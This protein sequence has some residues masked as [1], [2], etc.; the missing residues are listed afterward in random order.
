MVRSEFENRNNW[1]AHVEPQSALT[2]ESGRANGAGRLAAAQNAIG[3]SGD[4][5]R[6]HITATFSMTPAYQLDVQKHS[7]R[8]PDAGIHV[9]SGHRLKIR[10][11]PATELR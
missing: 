9:T 1:S 10:T 6:R 5:M 11:G 3:D 8:I 2:R 4:K 7:T